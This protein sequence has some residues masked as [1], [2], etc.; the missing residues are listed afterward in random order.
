MGD[1]RG[2][3]KIFYTEME[4]GG[5]GDLKCKLLRASSEIF[6]V[7]CIYYFSKKLASI[8]IYIF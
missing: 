8:S 6:H 2:D 5:D 7:L 1:L 3:L 4:G